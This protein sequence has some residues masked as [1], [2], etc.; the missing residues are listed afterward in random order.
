MTKQEIAAKLRQAVRLMNDNGAH[1]VQGDYTEIVGDRYNDPEYGYC[2][3]GAIR[4]VVGDPLED[5]S[6]ESDVV[7]LALASVL[8]AQRGEG[9]YNR[10]PERE[11]YSIAYDRITSWNDDDDREWWEIAEKFEEAAAKIEQP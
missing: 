3:L 10:D 4:H 7:A 1:W 9:Q 6:A 2:S 11:E 8:P 5:P